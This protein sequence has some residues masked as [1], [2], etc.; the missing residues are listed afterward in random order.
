MASRVTVSDPFS[1]FSIALNFLILLRKQVGAQ[2]LKSG[3]LVKY[4]FRQPGKSA[5]IYLPIICALL[6][7]RL[8]VLLFFQTFY[9]SFL[10]CLSFL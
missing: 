5:G 2:A 7:A 9:L 10:F 6:Y 8:Y 3:C 1:H 4:F